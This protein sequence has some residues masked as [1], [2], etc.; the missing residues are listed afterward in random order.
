MKILVSGMQ[1]T[2]ELHLGNYLGALANWVRL[3]HQYQCFFFIADYHAMTIKSDP[4]EM[5]HRIKNLILTY[6]SAGLSPEKCTI[7]IQSHLKE[8][9][10]LGWIFQT[11]TQIGELERMTQYKDKSKQNKENINAGL[12]SYPSLMAADILMY[13]ADGVPVGEDQTQHVELTRIL[14][15]RFNTRFGK[16][17]PEP[18]TI[19]TPA[20]RV[21]SLADPTK[22]MSKSL[23]EK[24]F[25]GLF[26]DPKLI[27]KKVMS[28][29]TD[30]GGSNQPVS[31]GV[32]NLFTLLEACEAPVEII[33]QLKD[34]HNAGTIKYIHLKEAV[35]E[36]IIKLVEPIQEKR[37]ELL[38]KPDYV[39]QAVA[40]GTEH[41]RKIC[42]KTMREVKQK[43]GLLA[44]V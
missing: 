21:M 19:L 18:Q 26:E 16:T 22:K 27:K 41:A 4:K 13:K 30:A 24:H 2:G 3:Q 17:F 34:Q 39:A 28:A 9:A 36:A 5:P 32:K 31:L 14:A 43:C 37:K 25:V 11:L 15:K 38:S 35:A 20:P 1:P 29:V 6:L 12:F 33:D 7:F 8:H 42:H 10:E 40:Q 44:D 23:G